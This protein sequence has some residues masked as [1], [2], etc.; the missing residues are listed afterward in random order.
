MQSTPLPMSLSTSPSG[1]GQIS[2][3]NSQ[4]GHLANNQSAQSNS[5]QF[6][7]T[8]KHLVI[9]TGMVILVLC[10]NIM[11]ERKRVNH[12]AMNLPSV[13]YPG[14]RYTL[15]PGMRVI[16]VRTAKGFYL[17][18]LDGHVLDG[19]HTPYGN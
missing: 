17:R 8:V 18:T 1:I 11:A 10:R 3:A 19:A 4:Y 13:S 14:H 6:K 7:S 12:L 16:S 9:H 2:W 15:Q 5:A